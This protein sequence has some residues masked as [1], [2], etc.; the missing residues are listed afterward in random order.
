MTAPPRVT[1]GERYWTTPP[2]E[3]SARCTWW[4]ERIRSGWKG[5]KRTRTLGYYAR[6][7]YFGVYIWEQL[8]VLDKEIRDRAAWQGLGPYQTR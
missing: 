5:N 1:D 3:P 2:P 7:D 8:N 4:V 6:A